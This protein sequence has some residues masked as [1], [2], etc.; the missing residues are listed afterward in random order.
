VS[1][2]VGKEGVDA[3]QASVDAVGGERTLG[4]VGD[5]D[6]DVGLVAEVL[7]NLG[8]GEVGG[9]RDFEG[10]NDGLPG[11]GGGGLGPNRLGIVVLHLLAG[12]GVEAFGH[13]AEPHLGEIGELRH[14]AHGRTR[15]LDRVGLRD[16]DRGPDVLDR[17]DLGLVSSSR[18]W[19]V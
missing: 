2:E 11:L 14:R 9:L 6:A 3:V 4:F 19:R 10:D 18:N 17:V 16:G 13:V 5:E 12:R 15:G 7:E 8:P 1:G